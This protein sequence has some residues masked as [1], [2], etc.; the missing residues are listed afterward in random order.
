MPAPA[1]HASCCLQDV[2]PR[3]LGS[4]S[5][6]Q[7]LAALTDPGL[8]ERFMRELREGGLR[9][10]ANMRFLVQESLSPNDTN[11][12]A[13]QKLIDA[14]VDALVIVANDRQQILGVVDRNHLIAKL[15]L[16]LAS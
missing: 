2:N 4:A 11:V 5:G 15:M 7:V 13:L 1:A 14:N 10:F 3:F 8:A 9:P 6:R 12:F 16:K